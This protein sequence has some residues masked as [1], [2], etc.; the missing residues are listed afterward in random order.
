MTK[1][2]I[3]RMTENQP[4]IIYIGNKETAES[5]LFRI[6]MNSKTPFVKKDNDYGI[7][8]EVTETRTEIQGKR[9]VPVTKA[10]RYFMQTLPENDNY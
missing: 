8:V 4:Q 9:H 5:K 10:A 7:E 1:T 3:I 2:A 6:L